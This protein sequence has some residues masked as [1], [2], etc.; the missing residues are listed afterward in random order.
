MPANAQHAAARIP[1][2]MVTARTQWYGCNKL[3]D[4]SPDNA[5][6]FIA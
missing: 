2:H 3:P 1:R 4:Y 5:L 6:F